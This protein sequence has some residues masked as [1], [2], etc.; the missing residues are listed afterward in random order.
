MNTAA[1]YTRVST[2]EQ[3]QHG[4]S[5]DAQVAKCAQY[6]KSSGLEVVYTGV[7]GESAKDTDRPELQ[8][9]LKMVAQKK[10]S[11]V[12]LVKLDRL[13]RD[14][15]DG[16]RIGKMLAKKGATL[17]LVAEGGR[18]DLS[19]PSQEMMFHMRISLGR[20]ERRRIAMNTKMAMAHKRDKNERISG[21]APY[22]YKFENNMVVEDETEQSVIQRVHT[23]HNSGMSI[24]KIIARL[25]SEGVYNRSGNEFT[26][27]AIHNI[28][29]AKAA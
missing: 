14:V 18:V 25:A 28:I 16:C 23:L 24:R 29:L 20:F 7:E 15:E 17:H 1:I 13:S 6:A 10:I 19:D 9:I 2:D 27:R 5:L 11:H 26:V 4:V 12:I 21:Q 3:K 22:G 8:T